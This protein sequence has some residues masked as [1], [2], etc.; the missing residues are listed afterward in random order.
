MNWRRRKSAV[1]REDLR[2]KVAANYLAGANQTEIARML[3]ISQPT[4]SRLLAE[5]EAEWR[6]LRLEDIDRRRLRM[7][8]RID[9]QINAFW[10][11]ALAGDLRAMDML[12]K[13]QDQE[14]KLFGLY[15]PTRQETKSVVVQTGVSVSVN[16]NVEIDFENL[17]DEA[18]RALG[19][20]YRAL[21]KMQ[22]GEGAE[23]PER[24]FERLLG[25]E[26]VDFI[27]AKGIHSAN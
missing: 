17:S 26:S 1:E 2:S 14:C 10:A 13:L 21:E 27:H 7:A 23:P 16:A 5:V 20:F 4:V 18:A 19:R 9:V 22:T 15:A 25:P 6:E 24:M 3:G 12:I 8:R 11:R